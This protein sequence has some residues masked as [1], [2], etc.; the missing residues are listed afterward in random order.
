MILF[1]S[2]TIFLAFENR[3]FPAA[4][5]FSA[6]ESQDLAAARSSNAFI[7]APAFRACSMANFASSIIIV[8]VT[9]AETGKHCTKTQIATGTITI[10]RARLKDPEVVPEGERARIEALSARFSR[11]DLLRAFDLVARTEAELRDEVGVATSLYVNDLAS[12]MEG[13]WSG[14]INVGTTQ[15]V[16]DLNGVAILSSGR[17]RQSGTIQFCIADLDKSGYVYAPAGT[18][19][20]SISR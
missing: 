2:S 4:Y 11:E 8:G 5:P 16:T 17:V 19:C 3:V 1:G 6:R 10:D 18:D 7:S 20:Q 13:L 14:I 9:A 15:K 12:D